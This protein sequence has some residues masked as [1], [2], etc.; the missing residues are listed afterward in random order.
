M[1]K[2]KEKIAGLDWQ[3][4]GI[5]LITK[6]LILFFSFQAYQIITNSPVN[7]WNDLLGIWRRWDAVHY[8]DIAQF[9]Y[10][11]VGERRFQLAFFPLYPLFVRIV[12]FLFGNYVLSGIIVSGIFSVTCG[13]LLKKLAALDYSKEIALSSVWFLFIF[14]TSY[15]LHLPYTESLFL[16]LIIGAFYFA[17]TK[18]WLLAGIC[19]QL[20]CMTRINGLFLIFALLCEIYCEYRETKRFNREWLWL[21]LIPTGFLFYLIINYTVTGDAFTFMTYQKEHW[22]KSLDYPWKGIKETFGSM[23]YRKPEESVMVGFQELFFVGLG[24]AAT[25]FSWLKQRKSYAVWMTLNW[26]LFVSTSFLLSIPRYTLAL[27]PMFMIFAYLSE[28]KYSIKILITVWS[29]LYLAIF[30]ALF[31]AGHWAF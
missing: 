6:F 1:E 15:F 27:F 23:L 20:A 7:S 21:L 2:L 14:P 24:F 22:S 31:A 9:G 12:S 19:G 11:S 8:L 10:T 26:L 17:R 30:T 4:V 5:A 13:L 25:V 29:I 28:K 3:V 18:N 16:T